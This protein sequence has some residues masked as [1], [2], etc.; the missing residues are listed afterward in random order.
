MKLLQIVPL[1][2][3]ATAFFNVEAQRFEISTGYNI[4]KM[5]GLD[6]NNFSDGIY[7]S[8][9][10]KFPVNEDWGIRPMFSYIDLGSNIEF[11]EGGIDREAEIEVSAL[12][13]GTDFYHETGKFEISAGLHY[14]FIGEHEIPSVLEE[15]IF[16]E[17]EI[18]D[19]TFSNNDLM[20]NFK[21]RYNLKFVFAE[22]T[23]RQG[24]LQQDDI[25]TTNLNTGLGLG[26][27]LRL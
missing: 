7:G 11:K 22:L 3:F 24:F 10:Y 8:I 27:G 1:L 20:L 14:A 19:A 12:T 5:T 13:L 4:N 6:G 16:D 17:E 23:F 9:G 21:F 18:N 15:N 26:L 2:F 25:S